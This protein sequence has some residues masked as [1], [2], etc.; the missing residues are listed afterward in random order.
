[1]HIAVISSSQ[2]SNSQSLR[3]SHSIGRRLEAAGATAE[4]HDLHKL[5][6][7]TDFEEVGE[8]DAAK[9]TVERLERSDGAVF[10]TPEW[11][12]MPSPGLLNFLLHIGTALAHKPVML[13][14]VS[15]G[16]GGAY[17]IAALRATGYKNS[18][19]VMI[20]EHLVFRNVKELMVDEAASSEDDDYIRRRTDFAV[21]T[22][23]A[24]AE[25][26]AA[27]RASLPVTPPDFRFGM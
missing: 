11:H 26:L 13:V 19:Y 9:P 3:I 5:A 18:K 8:T 6:L 20:P 23:L 27:V 15:S 24:Y 17:P 10:V 21:A 25:G 12:G 22:L 4:V 7:S 16:R 1:M 2:R 14:G